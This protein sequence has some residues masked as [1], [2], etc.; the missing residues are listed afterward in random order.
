MKYRSFQILLLIFG[1]LLL[2]GCHKLE[3]TT[4]VEP[5]GSGEL[6]MG[7]GFSPEERANMEK[8]GSNPQDFCNVAQAPPN[9]TV[10]EEQRGEE[11]WCI[12]VT[13]FDDLEELRSLYEQRRGITINRL[14][15]SDGKLYYDV[16]LDT[17][18][19]ESNFSALTEIT[20][21]V[22]V[23]GALID[24]NADQV[25]G[26]T[27]TWR[28]APKSGII[29]LRAQ[30]EVPRSGFILLLGITALLIFGAVF[31]II[32]HRRAR[33]TKVQV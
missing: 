17:S 20:W 15:I 6:R 2:A 13:Q 11:I 21:S 3:A 30:S 31:F 27:L 28:P 7:G 24:H 5:D 12:N 14:E 19:E 32:T 1:I 29:R 4:R 25:D 8:Q 22:V 18:S 26:N 16:D 10:I 33:R 9:V 23:P